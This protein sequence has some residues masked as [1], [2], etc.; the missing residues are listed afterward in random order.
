MTNFSATLPNE[1]ITAI[2]AFCNPITCGRAS[3]VCKTWYFAFAERNIIFDGDINAENIDVIKKMVRIERISV[4]NGNVYFCDVNIFSNL[5]R[6]TGDM[7]STNHITSVAGLKNLVSVGKSLN[8]CDCTLLSSVDGLANLKTVGDHLVFTKCYS[9]KSIT[10]LS[11]LVSV[12]SNLYAES[13]T[14]IS[15]VYNKQF[16]VNGKVIVLV[17]R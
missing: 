13:T 5:C 8:F 9:L 3:Q 10:E 2:S 12:G 6:I 7:V 16:A 14:S 1:M 17:S 11:S 15:S 4:I